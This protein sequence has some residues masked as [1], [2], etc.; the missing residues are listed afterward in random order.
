[1]NKTYQEIKPRR[2]M[3]IARQIL[4]SILLI[5]SLFTLFTTCL[6][7]YIDYKQDLAAIEERFV[8]IED[9]YLSSLVSSLWVE[10]R[11]QL[12][13]QAEGIMHLPGL[14][15]LEIT[16]SDGAIIRI[17]SELPK[18]MHQKSWDMVYKL[19]NKEYNLAT[20]TVQSDLYVVYQGLIDK[21][22]LLLL[23]QAVQ[24]FVIAVFIILIMYR[25]VVQPLTQM[26]RT[27]SEFDADKVPKAIHLRERW[28]EDEMSILSNSYNQ[29]VERI[30]EHYY[31]LE[32][33]RE[34][35]EQANRKKSEFLANMSHEIRTPMNGII[36]LSSLM[37]EMDMPQEQKEYVNM[38]N[39][40]SL[41]LLDLI[42]DILDFSKIE[43]GRLE[44]EHNVLNL[45]ELNKEVESVFLVRAAEKSLAFRCSIDR[46]I[47]PMLLGDATKLRQVLNNLVSNAIKFTEKG[48]VNLYIHR[49]DE[50]HKSVSVRFEV[51][52][53]GIGVPAEMHEAIFEKFQQADGSTTRKYGGT[54]LGLAICR[55][56][57]RLMG[58]ELELSS[59]PGKGSKF[60]FVLRLEKN[61]LPTASSADVKLL[62]DLSVLLV[63]DSMLNMRIT[64]AQLSNFGAKSTCCENAT[65]AADFVLQA[66][67]TKK[68]Y[69]LI[70]ID[71]IMPEING[72]ELA[73]Q[74]RIQF[75]A[76]CPKMM[77]ISAG[78]EVG[79]EE[80]ARKSGIR[81]YLA[82]PYKEANLKWAVQQVV[83]S[84]DI[85]M[86]E[87][88]NDLL[89]VSDNQQL[90]KPMQT[91]PEAY[92]RASKQSSRY[93]TAGNSDVSSG[94]SSE[95]MMLQEQDDKHENRQVRVLVVE[96][97]VVNQK[98]AQMMLEKLGAKVDIADN[99]QIAVAKYSKEEFDLIFMDCQMPVLDG[100]KATATIRE[101]EPEGKRIPIIALTA[102]VV[103]EEKD[104]CYD[105]GMDDFVSKPVSQQMLAAMLE[106]YWSSS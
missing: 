1:M 13:T 96:D 86:T 21:F 89:T 4:F 25:L 106:K 71:K 29:S 17:G 34:Y 70:V 78:P 42:N 90:L 59:K 12:A 24:I 49:E 102:N 67:R 93:K 52:D 97:T 54:G 19:G 69:D 51:S 91:M 30:R 18:Y 38:L 99:G 39:T 61:I 28:F 98:V 56:I 46:N 84:N 66:I 58:G 62:S 55:E 101:L 48:F 82:R 16:D 33:A 73:K 104:K 94:T 45:F 31:Q 68:P 75:A 60:S 10:D 14:H 32:E 36:G 83:R 11:E 44:L 63:D 3:G 43:A 47:S 23:S 80:K 79:D 15:Y 105:A 77:M 87:L 76:R 37:K 74:L 100:F 57:I 35:A 85:D 50:D 5:S 27:V 64:S 2:K 8:Q 22:I 103:K 95:L 7:L 72:F 65:E 40:S 26:S 6:N 92:L 88:D 81:S 9:S 53:S 41:S 20:L